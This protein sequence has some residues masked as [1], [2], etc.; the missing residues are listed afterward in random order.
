MGSLLGSCPKEKEMRG[1]TSKGICHPDLNFHF[2][3]FWLIEEAL[4]QDTGQQSVGWTWGTV[5]A[6]PDDVD[7]I[8]A[9]HRTLQDNVLICNLQENAAPASSLCGKSH[10]ASVCHVE[11][12]CFDG[13]G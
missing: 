12:Q 1:W 2:V 5:L 10:R 11:D 13:Y 8:S 6:I 4:G 3:S 9:R 7:A